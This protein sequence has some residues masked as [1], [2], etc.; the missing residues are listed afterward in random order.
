MADLFA[1]VVIIGTALNKG[2]HYSIPSRLAGTVQAGSRVSVELGKRKAAGIVLCVVSC[3]PELPQSIKIRPILDVSGELPAIPPDLLKLCLWL[4][5]YYFYPPGEVFDL[6]V[7]SGSGNLIQAGSASPPMSVSEV[8]PKARAPELTGDQSAA[9][10]ETAP[11]MDS[12]SFQPFVLY[13]VTGSGK[14]EVYLHLI[15]KAAQSGNGSLVLVPE[16]A[17]SAQMESIFRERFGDR[18]A[19]WHSSLAEK[20]RRIAWADIRTGRKKIVL[21][22][23]S[24][25]LTPVQRLKLIIVDEEHDTSYKQEDHLR[26]NARD[27]ALMRGK[28]VDAP[29][30]MGSATPS[31]QTIYRCSEKSYR[32]ILLPSRVQNKTPP[33]FE[34]VDMRLEGGRRGIF[35]YRL[36]EAIGETIR[37]SRQ[38]L[39]FL[40]RRGYDT[41]YLCNACGHALQCESCSVTLTYHKKDNRLRCHYCG[42]ETSLPERCPIC[43]HAALFSHGFGT[44]KVEKEV[45]RLFPEARVVRM[46]RDTMKNRDQLLSALD[47]VRSGKADVL[48]GTQMV[49]KGHDFPNITLV[50]IINADAGLQAPDFR[51]GEVLVQLLIQVA[52]RA[53]R[54]EEPGRV[55]VQTY[56]PSHFTIES[57]IKLD[58]DGFCREELKSRENLQYPPFTRLLK[59]LVTSVNEES[60]RAGARLLAAV[61]REK[62]ES[63]RNMGR[64]VAILG[65]S[66][67]AYA[68]LKNRFRWQVYLKTWTSSDMQNF[69]ESVLDSIKG[70]PALR[71]VQITVDRDPATEI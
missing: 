8:A 41:H 51:A 1:E 13:G 56:N 7:P 70:D 61:C 42:W 5:S 60:A 17:I 12:P 10:D 68:K 47:A 26:Y 65:P 14:T 15:E 23:R 69:T 11:F 49:A 46:D 6:V 40:N 9:L 25:V 29:V 4:S 50:G 45:K 57:A 31:I 59:I 38:A 37:S 55:I 22:A 71:S 27:V 66:P 18:V 3:L 67:A 43:A 28:I 24:A 34:I 48:L 19:V 21:G 30:I 32:S 58:Y 53:G 20:E 52:G 44:E 2:L 64:S 36:R 35:S 33:G 39:L 54:G 63:F 62:A 16:I